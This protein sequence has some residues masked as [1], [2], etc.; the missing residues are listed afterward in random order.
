MAEIRVPLT[1]EQ[2]TM[3]AQADQAASVAQQIK[4]ATFEAVC[5]GH[6]AKADLARTKAIRLDV[7]AIVVTVADS[8]VVVDQRVP[9]GTEPPAVVPHE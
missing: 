8:P 2:A 4:V 6:I 7:D 9:D 3:L 1:P 5:L